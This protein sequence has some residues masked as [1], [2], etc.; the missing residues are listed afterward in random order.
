VLRYLS[1]HHADLLAALQTVVEE[2]SA[3][4]AAD[5]NQSPLVTLERAV[6]A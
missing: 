6:D 2:V 5:P 4:S 1:Q 3:N